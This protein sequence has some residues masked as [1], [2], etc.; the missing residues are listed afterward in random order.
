MADRLACR[1]TLDGAKDQ[2][3]E[4]AAGEARDHGETH[5]LDARDARL[6]PRL[7]ER[8]GRVEGRTS[9]TSGP[10][11]G[12]WFSLGPAFASLDSGATSMRSGFAPFASVLDSAPLPF[13]LPSCGASVISSGVVVPFTRPSHSLRNSAASA[14]A[15][16]HR[17][18]TSRSRRSWLTRC[19]RS[20]AASASTSRRR[21]A[22]SCVVWSM[23][24][25]RRSVPNAVMAKTTARMR[26][27]VGADERWSW[28][29]TRWRVERVVLSSSSSPWS[30]RCQMPCRG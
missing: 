13:P 23:R 3:E 30:V 29:E 24:W 27:I 12:V 26:P 10:G 28:G 2:T 9:L 11:A 8:A 17:S 19:L 6:L 16:V 4:R 22:S 21:S 20:S 15:T 1:A 14:S 5:L 7:C 18:A 25:R